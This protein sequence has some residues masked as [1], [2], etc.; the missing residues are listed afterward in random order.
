MKSFYFLIFSF[1]FL[2]VFNSCDT[3]DVITSL[4]G[5]VYRGPINPVEIMGVENNAPFSALFHVYDENQKRL[6]NS[7]ISNV[8]GKYQVILAPGN[9]KIIPDIS[10]PIIHPTSQIKN[11]TVN[12]SDVTTL[13][14]YFDTGIR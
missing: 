3:S 14:L 5:K 10:A 9:Y 6:I 8:E 2:S 11:I 7:F 4:E 13:D 12:N 1:L